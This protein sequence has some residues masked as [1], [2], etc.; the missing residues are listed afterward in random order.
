L[1]LP[2]ILDAA[3]ALIERDG[4]PALSMRGL[5]RE[6]G[7]EAMALYRYVPNY[8]ALID[9]V[10]NRVVDDL[11]DSPDMDM[12][13]DLDWREFLSCHAHGLR[14]MALDKPAVFPLVATHPPQAP[15]VRPPLRS[16]RWVED[17]LEGLLGRGFAEQG[18]IDAYRL[19]SSFLLGHLLLEVSA[20]GVPVGPA[21]PATEPSQA[22]P[23]GPVLDRE[24]AGFPALTRLAGRMGDHHPDEAFQSEL[25]GLLDRLEHLNGLPL[26]TALGP[27]T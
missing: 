4:V 18:A 17:F 11:L 14:A 6:L 9:A 21:E 12:P 24:L 16:L 19:F 8:E 10:V 22:Q 3:L 7:V 5:G 23:S 27:G 15:W 26:P 1:S 13:A 20:L 2:R 25:T